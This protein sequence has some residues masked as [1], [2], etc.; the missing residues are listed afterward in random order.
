MESSTLFMPAS[1]TS[2][3]TCRSRIS[4][5][6]RPE[7]QL[8][9][10]VFL[11]FKDL[12]QRVHLPAHVLHH[13]VHGVDLDTRLSESAP[14]AKRMAMCSAAFISRGVCVGCSAEA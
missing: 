8:A 14:R 12:A 11:N 10:L 13:L 5:G 1:G 2:A 6:I 3:R 4:R 9:H 7:C